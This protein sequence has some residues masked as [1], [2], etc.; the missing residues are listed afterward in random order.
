M[1]TLVHGQLWLALLT[2]GCDP[3]TT[4][5][6]APVLQDAFACMEVEIDTEC[7]A[8]DSAHPGDFTHHNCGARVMDVT[9]E[10][11]YEEYEAHSGSVIAL[12]CFA[13]V[14]VRVEDCTS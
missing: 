8:M 7:P 6:D 3:G 11:D 9:S 12:C 13:V 5:T 10:G 4:P 1:R 14:Q 2:H